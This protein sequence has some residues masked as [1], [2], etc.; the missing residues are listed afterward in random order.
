MASLVLTGH[1]RPVDPQHDL[2]SI[3][4]LIDLCFSGQMDDDGRDYLR[5]IRRAA[6]DSSLRR[7][8][9]GA[10]ERV[11]IPLFGYVWEEDQRL[12]GNL[13]LIPFYREAKWRYLIANVATNPDYRRRGIARAL[14]QKAIEHA[15]SHGVSEVWLQVRDDN[16][17]AHHLYMELGFI[18]R[19]RRSTW[20]LSESPPPLQPFDQLT[21]CRRQA[22]DWP[23]QKQWLE[24][25]YPPE[26]AWNLNFKSTRY[27]AGFWGDL[28]RF[29]AND[30]IEQW[31]VRDNDRFLGVAIWDAAAS[32][33]ETTWVAPNPACEEF[34][35]SALLTILRRQT[36]LARRLTLNY[37][38]GRGINAFTQTGFVLR[39]TLIWMRINFEASA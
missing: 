8:V 29:F 32:N 27:A 37:P 21:V 26:V 7:W 36:G 20:Q 24:Q 14:T 31:S 19:V 33:A 2:N 6:Q 23:A 10:N 9:T 13:T 11:S 25:I 5:H 4:D 16:P 30:K 3:A 39:N 22:S 28:K 12:V 15:H 34:A 18:E 17:V 1:L 38:A 35:L